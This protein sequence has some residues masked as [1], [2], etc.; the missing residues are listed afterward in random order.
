MAVTPAASLEGTA[1]GGPEVHCE[2]GASGLAACVPRADVVVI[3]DVLSF[4]TCV[5]IA[6]SRGAAVFPFAWRDER[7]AAFARE[8]GAELA[9]PRGQAPLSLSPATFLGV[10][11][12]MRVVLPSPNGATLSRQAGHGPILTGCL[13]NAAAVGQAAGGI[14]R[15]VLVVPAGE[16]WSDGSL[17]PCL[18]DWIGAGAI[19]EALGGSCSPEAEAARAAFRVAR[20]DL[21]RL[22]CGCASGQ[23]L[24][25]RGYREDVGLAAALNVSAAVPILADG[26]Y[27][28]LAAAHGR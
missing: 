24:I 26:A 14:G 2:W 13:R 5:E 19:A 11:P 20:P 6:V 21:A 23:E 8:V 28:P 1:P 9:G 16:R 10:S 25:D 4:S 22:L 7:A 17:R 12:G 3:V 18:E 15:R 27:R